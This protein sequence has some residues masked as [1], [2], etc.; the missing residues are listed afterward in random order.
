MTVVWKVV[1]TIVLFSIIVTDAN[2]ARRRRRQTILNAGQQ[3][4]N[5]NSQANAYKSQPEARRQPLPPNPQ[6]LNAQGQQMSQSGIGI[7]NDAKAASGQD[8]RQYGY[9]GQFGYGTAQGSNY[10]YN[11]GGQYGQYGQGMGQYGQGMGQYGQG[12]GQYGQGMGQY[13]SYNYPYQGSNY[14][15][16]YGSG[17]NP[18][19]YASNYYPQSGGNYGGYG[20]GGHF[21][22]A[23]QKQNINMCTIF[24]SSLL[25]LAIGLIVV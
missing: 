24:L 10:P 7:Q 18:S 12:M 22:N 25:A 6:I 15:S 17:Y 21:W 9:Q 20:S 4:A 13:G 1:L 2:R 5:L 8:G 19:G 23:G 16:G 11:Y 3:P 14:Y